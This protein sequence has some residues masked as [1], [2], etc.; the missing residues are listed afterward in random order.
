MHFVIACL[1][2]LR[3]DHRAL[4]DCKHCIDEV[5]R[6]CLNRVWHRGCRRPMR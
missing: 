1:I 6:A 2:L 5:C 3:L 4:Y